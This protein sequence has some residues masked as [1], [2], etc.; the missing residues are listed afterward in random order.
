MPFNV[1]L[2]RGRGGREG[3]AAFRAPRLEQKRLHT[4]ADPMS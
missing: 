4:A 3:P 2:S 1:V